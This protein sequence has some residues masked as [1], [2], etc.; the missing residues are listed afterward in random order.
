MK[1]SDLIWQ[2]SQHQELL[3]LVQRL[4]D[5]SDNGIDIMDKLSDY[6]AHHFMLEEK[7]MELS[8]F[9]GAEAHIR[10]H[11]LFAKKVE[12]MQSSRTLLSQGLKN[13]K[14]RREITDF[15]TDWLLTHVM[16]MDKELEL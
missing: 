13:P 3:V 16:G 7:Y 11:R 2:D 15:L 12:S 9:P 1:T 14:F 4:R 8:H 10:A 5:S 6:V